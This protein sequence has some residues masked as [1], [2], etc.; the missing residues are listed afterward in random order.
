M[1]EDVGNRPSPETAKRFAEYLTKRAAGESLDLSQLLA[2][3]PEFEREFLALERAWKSVQD[4]LEQL[5][6][7]PA[8]TRCLSKSRRRQ[9]GSALNS[10]ERALLEEVVQRLAQRA[11]NF[12][13]Y[14]VEGEVGSGGMGAVMRVWDSD[15]RRDLA[16]KV[17]LDPGET[18]PDHQLD[19]RVLTRFIEEA[20][21]TGQLDHPG[22]VPVHEL[23][24][25]GEGRVYFTMRLVSG[26]DLKEIFK[27]VQ[28][29][30][31]GWSITRATGVLLKVC[32]AMAYA[33]SKG[34][35]HRD[36]KPANVMIGRFGE[37]YV[38]D[39]GLAHVFTNEVRK[40]K[41]DD[42]ST[43][44]Y[45][46][47]QAAL[48]ADQSA[49][50][51]LDGDVVGTPAYMPPEQASGDHAQVDPLSDVYSAGAILY[52]LLSGRVPYVDP[53]ERPSAFDVWK[54]VREGPPA[55]IE[56]CNPEAPAELVA[57]CEK[58]MSREKQDRYVGMSEMA[59]DLRAYLEGRVV[60]AYETGA[61]AE[62][63]KWVR[64][65]KALATTLLAS[66]VLI[67]TGSLVASLI[68]ADK[69]KE[70]GTKNIELGKAN[71]KANR[72]ERLATQAA[73]D[74][75]RNAVLAQEKADEVLRL[76]DV[77]G[78][79]DLKQQA[80]TLWP[81]L[82]NHQ[83]E[84]EDWLDK[85]NDL[86]QRLT[87][88]SATLLRL[89]S[90]AVSSEPF[91]FASTEDQW[92]HDTLAGLVDELRK[93]LDAEYGLIADV[94]WRLEFARTIREK[95]LTS[96]DARRRWEEA[97]A[98]AESS[99]L[100]EGV[101]LTP[102]LG[103]LPLGEDPESGLL[104]FAHLQSGDPAL[105]S[106]SDE[107]E[108][109]EDSGVVLVLI[110]G[111]EFLMGSQLDDESAE[112]FSEH[113]NEKEMPPHQVRVGPYFLSKYELTQGQW[114]RATGS[115][116]SLYGPDVSFGEIDH[117]LL[118]PVEQISWNDVTEV[119]HRLGLLLP[120][121]AQW[122]FACRAGSR[123]PWFSG[124]DRE[125]LVGHA[126]LADASVARAGE[127]WPTLEDWP[128]FDDGYPLHAPVGTF[129]P[130]KY[131]LHDMSGNVW[132]WC[133]DGFGFYD[134]PVSGLDSEREATHPQ[135]KVNR[136]GSYYHTARHAR[137]SH[138]NNSAP[139]TRQNHIGVRLSRELEP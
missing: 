70:L 54:R 79:A 60:H 9:G 44:I 45:T 32:E 10:R 121:E 14:E 42:T 118:H 86:S 89:R 135:F 49:Q 48:A 90:R 76:S 106:T 29:G 52:H 56:E 58:A 12:T 82:P 85:A 23:G 65:N 108:L 115:N 21:V 83:Q 27:L 98:Y 47:L 39:W 113:A 137:A 55:P 105:R 112:N 127:A 131:G 103:L 81:P 28:T 46:D 41:P 6:L 37:A 61:I 51:T 130:N 7:S 119:A 95:S 26:R 11:S 67:T 91:L 123:D 24:V 128:E 80:E 94:E 77:T 3:S 84:L 125:S 50:V 33:H 8:V 2:D 92:Q 111:D 18:D 53:N 15:L 129:L 99:G 132:E 30:E 133:R 20:Q 16:M 73:A 97:M 68:L 104:E 138:R 43:K 114:L 136:G 57:I 87:L 107:L 110:P 62:F 101:S 17:V 25:D 139:E 1:N 75:T 22:I 88:H 96:P 63:R 124:F 66:I 134:S 5:G 117:N 34:V 74:A 4:V 120:T 35:I 36:L 19:P 93:M 40:H 126:N 38:M 31:D 13:R 59:D 71:E 122:E 78:I 116:P 72:N 100:Y 109:T 102:Q 64:R 69:N